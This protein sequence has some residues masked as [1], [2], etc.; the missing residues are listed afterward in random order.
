M[1][2]LIDNLEFVALKSRMLNQTT[3]E[4]FRYGVQGGRQVANYYDENRKLVAQKIRGRDK[5]FACTGDLSQAMLFGQQLWK[6]GGKQLVITEGELD[7]LS[8]AQALSPQL[9]WPVVSIP[10]GASGAAKAIRKNLT[11]VE[12]FD[13][14]ILAFD[15]DE[16]GQKAALECAKILKPGTVRIAQY[17]EG[18]KDAS[19][20][21]KQGA[22]LGHWLR[23]KSVDYRP[24]GI[25]NGVD[26]WE[27]IMD[28]R[29]GK[30]AESFPLRYPKIQE[31]IRGLRKGELCMLTAGTG[32]GKSTL[33]HE[34]GYDLMT[35]HGLKL[36]VAALEESD[37][38]T[39]MRYLSIHLN[40]RLHLDPQSATV[41]EYEE[42]FKATTGSG[43]L[44]LYDHFGSLES[45]ALLDKIRYLAVGEECDFI[46]LDHISIAV[47][48]IATDD[49]RKTLD[50]LMTKLRQICENTGVG[51]IAV[52]HLRRK[53]NSQS[54][55]EDGGRVSIADLRGSGSIAQLS[56]T[57]IANERDQQ[58]DS[59]PTRL[60][61]LKCRWTGRTGEADNL[62]FNIETG[63]YT[64]YEDEPDAYGFNPEDNNDF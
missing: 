58:D 53:G 5:Q 18:C 36:G 51:I 30:C 37:R 23:F 54:A 27:T 62:K 29:E 7:A 61:V 55:H 20:C 15:A 12:S 24:D 17:P 41:E 4:R 45:D 43:R 3:C 26:L 2:D 42:A 52:C 11:F 60:R 44:V 10:N 32:A 48:G 6:A 63:R 9:S 59:V 35:E 14:V 8:A 49:E 22:D 13:T 40:R 39:G 33:A 56:D 38:I 1:G 21:L 19:D 50:V 31:M 25:V 64:L 47:S 46:I 28:F 57:I 34:I 16:V